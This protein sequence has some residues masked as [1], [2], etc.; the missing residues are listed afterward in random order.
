MRKLIWKS[1]LILLFTFTWN[2]PSAFAQFED[3]GVGARGIGMGNAFIGLA[4]DGYAIYYNPA[5]LGRIEWKELVLDYG[6]LYWGLDDNSSLGQSFVGYAQSLNRLGTLGVGWL[7]FA[8][9]RYYREDT[10]MFAYGK[11]I[12]HSKGGSSLAAGLNLKVLYKGFEKTIYT[13]NAIDLD[14]TQRK[15]GRDPVFE[16]GYSR[17][18]FSTDLGLLYDLGRHHSIALTLNDINQPD[19]GLA[20]RDKIA[21]A[22][23]LGYAYRS[24]NF[25]MTSDLTF[26]GRD[27]TVSAGTEKWFM[28]KTLAVRA[29]LG[30]GEREYASLS[31]GASYRYSR[32]FQFDYSFVYPLRGISSFSGS[33]RFSLTLRFGVKGPEE[34]LEEEL[35][36]TKSE[37]E[38]A[39][40]AA[41]KARLETEEIMKEKEIS[42]TEIR[43]VQER[44]RQT[45]ETLRRLEEELRRIKERRQ[46]EKV[47]KK[48]V[49][50][51]YWGKGFSYYQKGEY[52]KA[53][54]ELEKILE[55]DPSHLESRRLIKQ[56]KEKIEKRRSKEEIEKR[57]TRGLKAY[58]EGRLKEAIK[59]WKEASKLDPENEKIRKAL[60][61]V[62]KELQLKE[63]R[64]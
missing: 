31:L 27:V 8:L 36:R 60:E 61:G 46:A 19:M 16:N 62:E 56:A 39:K 30:I 43:E 21:L 10:F 57:Y 6:K 12:S 4:D 15:G 25:N 34:E 40:E 18:G 33:H 63:E 26:K 14:T 58:S 5:G 51:R 13:E 28:G 50:R 38:S 44:Q 64:K 32:L 23:K 49:M 3:L 20:D 35:E 2:L 1:I 54:T 47:T 7:N 52:E 45:E 48:E 59:E 55:L 41:E 24:R 29:G 53:I 22:T 9:T 37:L 42:E 17:T 11:R